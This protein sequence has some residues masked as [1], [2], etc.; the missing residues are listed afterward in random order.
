MTPPIAGGCNF[1]ASSPI[2]LIFS[3]TNAPR[4]GL[5]LLIRHN[6][7][8]GPPPKMVSKPYLKCLDTSMHSLYIF[9]TPHIKLKLG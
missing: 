6:K 2:L 3:V 9:A 5:H 1:L 8:W 7:Q 4:R